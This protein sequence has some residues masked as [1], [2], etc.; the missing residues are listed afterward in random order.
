M[1][2]SEAAAQAE[3]VA[4]PAGGSPSAPAVDAAAQ[5]RSSGYVRLLL[6]AALI[7]VPISAAAYFF[8]QFVGLLQGWVFRSLPRALGF[9]AAPLWWPLPILG[10]AGVLVGVAIRHLPG[11][12]GHSP[13]GGFVAGGAPTP[14]ELPGVLF[15]ALASL[16]LGVVLG[17]EAPLIALGAGLAVCAVRL[18]RRDVP[19]QVGAVV[20]AAGSFAAISA[21]LGSPILGAFL[22]M[23]ASGLG[24]A[25]LGLVLLPGLLAA[26]IG[27]L[28]FVGLDAMTGLG[29]ASLALPGMPPF[30]RPDVVQ[31]GWALVIGLLAAVVGS[32]VRRLALLLRAHVERRIVVLTPVVGLAVAGLAIGYEAGTGHSSSDVLFSGETAMGPLLQGS[33]GYSVGALL[34]L[35]V[36]KSLAYALSLSSFRGGPVFPSMFLGAAGGVA[37]SHLPGLPLV[38]GVAMGI[39]AMCVVMLKLPLTSVL[40]ATLLLFSDGLAVMPLVIVAVVVAHVVSARLTPAPGPAGEPGGPRPGHPGRVMRDGGPR[41]DPSGTDADMPHVVRKTPGA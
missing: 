22:L 15:A 33:T 3:G 38:A 30:D 25:T 31:F 21:L 36:G 17:P 29:E 41:E 13:A 16:S 40:L 39:G 1:A 18:A 23:E 34:M 26:G 2:D 9:T 28:V 7:G 19:Q 10:L 11:G 32:G 6:L 8:L 37:L 5:L 14:A 20:A 35:L 4:G 12:G 27:S 24:G